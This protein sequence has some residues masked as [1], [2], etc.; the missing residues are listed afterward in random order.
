MSS[1]SPHLPL[2]SAHR[3]RGNLATSFYRNMNNFMGTAVLDLDLTNGSPTTDIAGILRSILS[4]TLS[5]VSSQKSSASERVIGSLKDLPLLAVPD[6]DC[7]ICYDPFQERNND[8]SGR[9]VCSQEVLDASKTLWQIQREHHV[10][11]YQ[12]ADLAQQFDDPSLFLPED[13]S[14][15]IHTRFPQRNIVTLEQPSNNQI[16][17]GSLSPREKF[18]QEIN[19]AGHTPVKMPSCE[20][21]FGR[22]C[23]IQ[24]L[25]TSVTCP[26]CRLEVEVGQDRPNK[27]ASIEQTSHLQFN[28]TQNALEHL[29]NHLT[30][31]FYP[32]RRPYAPQITSL[33]DSFM[34]QSM[35]TPARYPSVSVPEPEIFV[36]RPFPVGEG[37]VL[38]SRAI[39]V[40]AAVVSG[41]ENNRILPWQRVQVQNRTGGPDRSRRSPLAQRRT[42]PYSRTE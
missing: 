12:P 26:L 19:E 39:P 36:P 42:H 30:N 1:L 10:H 37:P 11:T 14:A 23:I 31:I 4:R 34:P 5:G 27:T 16:V 13:E 24:W 29:E 7:P 25:K 18:Q 35:V 2:P 3:F 20:H 41:G 38:V 32:Y 6:S 40:P 33:T 21:I 9:H 17:P 22:A 28:D 15:G 8:I